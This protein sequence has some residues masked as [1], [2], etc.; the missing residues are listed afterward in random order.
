[1]SVASHVFILTFNFSLS[2]Y[3]H[4]QLGLTS[5]LERF[6]YHFLL[7]L[8][9]SH[10]S[11]PITIIS[12]FPFPTF[13]FA[14]SPLYPP[15]TSRFNFFHPLLPSNCSSPTFYLP[16]LTFHFLTSF[17]FPHPAFPLIFP[18]SHFYL[19]SWRLIA[20]APNSWYLSN[21]ITVCHFNTSFFFF[22]FFLALNSATAKQ[23]V[24][25][26]KSTRFNS[27]DG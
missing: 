5:L 6:T 1:M 27:T 24:L 22:H 14:M 15:S 26:T 21:E 9:T 12:R 2:A 17:E 4:S 13:F 7:W 11:P 8:L 10:L 16:F 20:K 3:L 25:G 18:T 19:Y 23:R